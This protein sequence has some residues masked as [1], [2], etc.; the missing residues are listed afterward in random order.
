VD[1]EDV[2]VHDAFYEVEQAPAGAA[3]ERASAGRP[4]QSVV[5]RHNG[6]T[7]LWRVVIPEGFLTKR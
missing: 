4:G 2:M 1:A 6:Q 5:R 3:K 7:S